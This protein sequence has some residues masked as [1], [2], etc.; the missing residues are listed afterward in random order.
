MDK[1]LTAAE[2][3]AKE[4]NDRLA[5]FQESI[6]KSASK[7]ALDSLILD[8]KEYQTKNA[9]NLTEYQT[10]FGD[11]EQRIKGMSDT[12]SKMPQTG[13]EGRTKNLATAIYEQFKS[14]AWDAHL[15]RRAEGESPV[16]QLKDITWGA[17]G[18]GG[19]NDV[20]HNFMPFQIPIYPFE[21]PVDMRS[22]VPLGTCDTGS[23]DYPQ[24]K[25]YTDG[26]KPKPETGASDET[27][28]TFEMKVEN[29]HRIATFAEVS[30]R[31]LRN[32]RWLA[33]YIAQRF[34]D[35]FVKVLNT[36]VLVGTGVGDNLTGLNT[37]ATSYT[38]AQPGYVDTIP[39]GE[40]TLWDAILA[41]NSQLYLKANVYANAL[42]VSPQ[43]QFGLTVQKATTREFAYDGVIV[44]VDEMGIWRVNGIAMFVTKDI[45][46][47]E[48]LMGVISSSVLELLSNGGITMDTTQ[49]HASNFT[50]SMVAFRF[51]TDILFPVYR[52]VAFIKGVLS[53]VQ[54][55]ITSA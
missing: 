22:I 27:D 24:E 26:M 37:I 35:K 8:M 7:D 29:A 52:P 48:V 55:D 14:E 43:T 4:I 11:L 32:T 1:E 42:F 30:R 40:S 10:K 47:G 50:A 9:D 20:V 34:M 16:M 54:G 15:E 25:V 23:L 2:K 51:E 3:M 53:A 31:A 21:E 49:S 36:Q 18:A 41:L 33:N 38:L 45:P 28:I 19:T 17:I 46:V 5:G 6:T 39:A 44:K 12:L 13:N